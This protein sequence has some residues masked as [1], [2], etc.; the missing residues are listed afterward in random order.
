MLELGVRD[1]ENLAGFRRAVHQRCQFQGFAA[2]NDRGYLGALS[3]GLAFR[4]PS[5]F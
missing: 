1:I 2:V 4:I 3:S 5:K